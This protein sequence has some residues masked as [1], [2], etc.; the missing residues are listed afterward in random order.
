VASLRLDQVTPELLD[1]IR[2]SGH[3]TLTLA[4]EAATER[5]RNAV[6]KPMS[7]TVVLAAAR[8][9]GA[10][11]IPRLKLYFQVG[12]PYETDEDVESI[13]PFIALI[14]A[15]LAEGAGTRNWATSLTVSANPFVAKPGTPFQWHTMASGKDM[16]A[17]LEYLKR[18]LKRLGGVSFSGTSPREAL[19][20]GLIARGDRRTG[21]ELWD[22]A[23]KR[24]YPYSILKV[25]PQYCPSPEWYIHRLR[26]KDEELP[27]DFIDHRVS[28][29]VLWHEYEKSMIARTTPACRPGKCRN[30]D[31]CLTAV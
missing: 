13:P 12:L 26:T 28:K 15:G 20:Q 6:N 25:A 16:K 7:N 22:R 11:N 2:D 3:R 10:S 27:W 23:G 19:V 8:M 4:P 1:D 9:A 24:G 29:N 18:E 17:K 14:K 30:C 31:A 5:L 21:L